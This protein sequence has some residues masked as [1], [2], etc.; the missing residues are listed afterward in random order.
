[1]IFLFIDGFN[2][3]TD[4]MSK[5]KFIMIGMIIGSI[6]G[7]YVPVLL[8]AESLSASLIGSA[9]GGFLGIWGAYRLHA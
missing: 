8:G 6:A 7:G 3:L 1:L 9:V 5:R 4:V 2:D